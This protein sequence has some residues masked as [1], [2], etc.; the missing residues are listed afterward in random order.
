M[1]RPGLHWVCIG[2]RAKGGETPPLRTFDAPIDLSVR[3]A[4]CPRICRGGVSPPFS[5]A[6]RISHNGPGGAC[7]AR[8]CTGYE[9]AARKGR[10]N[11]A[12]TDLRPSTP[13]LAFRCAVPGVP[14][15]VGAAS[16]RPF[17]MRTA[18]P[19]TARAAHAP[20][21]PARDMKGRR[22][23]GGE[24]PPLRTFDALPQQHQHRDLT[25]PRRPGGARAGAAAVGGLGDDPVGGA[26]QVGEGDLAGGICGGMS[27]SRRWSRGRGRRGGVSPLYSG[28]A[29][30]PNNGPGGACAARAFT[31]FA[32]G[33][34]QRA[35]KRRPYGP[36]TFDAPIHFSARRARCPRT[37]RGGACAARACTGYEG[38]APKGRRDAA[39]TDL[40]RP[41]A[42]TPTPPP[43]SST[44]S[45][46][47][48]SWCC[49]RRGTWRRRGRPSRGDRRR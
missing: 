23:K 24:T 5:D 37:C 25:R 34:A 31:G 18:F 42:T 1:R 32:L 20:P 44:A 43:H 8:A 11:A 19:T 3:R 39:P 47:R 12:P 16:R 27:G 38:T 28:S 10:R 46:W 36:S 2:V 15:P 6:H 14:G 35:A 29:S 22:A 4:R 13:Q 41:T 30:Q 49:C 40:R 21:G 48:S 26:R 45:R 7:A 9:G 33:C 17:R